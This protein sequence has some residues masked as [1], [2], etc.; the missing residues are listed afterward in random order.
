MEIETKITVAIRK[1]P[2]TK[3]EQLKNEKD[4]IE[5]IEPNT[6]IVKELRFF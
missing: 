4:I 6:L 3:Q 2:F 1:R 5:V